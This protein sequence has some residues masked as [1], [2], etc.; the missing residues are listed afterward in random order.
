[1]SSSQHC[2]RIASPRLSSMHE[3]RKRLR[4][5]R[6]KSAC[7]RKTAGTRA[8]A[9]ASTSDPRTSYKVVGTSLKKKRNSAIKKNEGEDR[10]M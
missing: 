4:R 2:A 8:K 5:G 1:M 9:I 7:R 6:K 10:E 3:R